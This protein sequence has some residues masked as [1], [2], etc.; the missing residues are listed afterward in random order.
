MST[1]T[2][3]SPPRGATAILALAGPA[4][5]RASS[6]PPSG[7]L[8]PPRYRTPRRP[9]AKLVTP[10]VKDAPMSSCVRGGLVEAPGVGVQGAV[11]DL[12]QVALEDAETGFSGL[13]LVLAA[14]LQQGG[15][16]G[17][18]A[19]LDQ[20]GAVEG[21]VELAVPA[22]VEAV[23]AV[24]AGAAG[25]GAVVPGVG[26]RAAEP[27]DIAGLAHDLGGGDHGDPRDGQQFRDQDGD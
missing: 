17:M 4:R 24:V 22:S 8:I 10:A 6:P 14:A 7:Y 12:G 9:S 25:G 16:A 1:E 5:S 26:G 19:G 13:V 23:G 20:G 15:G 18:A 3:S 21:R 27:A 11:D 2:E